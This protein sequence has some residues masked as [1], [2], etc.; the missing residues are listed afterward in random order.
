M[1]RSIQCKVLHFDH[2]GSRPGS[3][4]ASDVDARSRLTVVV[5]M[6]TILTRIGFSHVRSMSEDLSIRPRILGL[7]RFL[8]DLGWSISAYYVD[9]F[10]LYQSWR[11]IP[12]HYARQCVTLISL[13]PVVEPSK[14]IIFPVTCSFSVVNRD[15]AFDRS[16]A[17][18][19]RYAKMT[20]W[21]I[22]MEIIIIHSCQVKILHC[23]LDSANNDQTVGRIFISF[24][25]HLTILWP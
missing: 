19:D 23:H 1:S 12:K 25:F 24:H 22:A 14:R 3:E 16:V 2:K 11:V 17:R 20:Y 5:R 9:H 18:H 4:N 7:D 10:H 15:T 8:S 13:P 6:R 21:N